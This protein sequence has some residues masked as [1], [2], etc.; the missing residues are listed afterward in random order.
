MLFVT[1]SNLGLLCQKNKTPGVV[2]QN[3]ASS[4]DSPESEDLELDDSPLC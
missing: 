1:L 3:T 2:A 4:G